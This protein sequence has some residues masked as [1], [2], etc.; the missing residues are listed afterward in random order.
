MD[1]VHG[2]VVQSLWITL[3]VSRWKQDRRSRFN[4]TEGVSAV[5]ITVVGLELNDRRYITE[6]VAV[7]QG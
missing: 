3:N 5:L 4:M 1:R 7:L 2:P 6:G